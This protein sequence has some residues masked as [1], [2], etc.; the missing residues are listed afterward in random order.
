MTNRGPADDADEPV[1]LPIDGN[2]DL[3]AFQP[4]DVADL[5]GTY[6]DECAARGIRD[7]RII[8]GKGIGTLRRIVHAV[9]D[10]R[11]DV[12]GY[13]TAGDGSGWGATLVALDD[14]REE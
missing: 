5:V 2:L 9:L 8:H 14:N 6:L 1:E 11:D 10:R 13:R 7:I 12:I 4:S 3:H